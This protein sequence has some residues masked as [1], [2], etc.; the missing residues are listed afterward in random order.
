MYPIESGIPMPVRS[1]E[2][3]FRKYP[4]RT[5]ELDQ[6]FMVPCVKDKQDDLSNSLTSNR[7]YAEK[8]TGFKF[9]TR[10][11]PDGIRVWRTK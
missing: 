6:S 7:R 3:T 8:Q 1:H 11:T 10:R 2:L 4:W 9:A 5:L